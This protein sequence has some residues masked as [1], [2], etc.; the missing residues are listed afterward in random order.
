MK[1]APIPSVYFI[2]ALCALG[3]TI[4]HFSIQLVNVDAT[5]FIYH[6]NSGWGSALVTTFFI[7]SGF[8]LHYHYGGDKLELRR[9]YVKRW[10]GLY[11][12]FYIA[13][14][15]FWMGKIC[16][17][18]GPFFNGQPLAYF[19]TV[20]GLDGYIDVRTTTYYIIG[21]WFV[22]AIAI[23]YL[24]YPLLYRGYRKTA[25]GSFAAVAAVYVIFYDKCITNVYGFWTVSSCL[26]SFAFGML[27]CEYRKHLTKLPVLLVS[28]VGFVITVTVPLPLG[29]NLC[30]HMAGA[31]LYLLLN[32]AGE[33]LMRRKWIHSL[34]RELGNLSYPIFLIHHQ[35][36][37]RVTGSWQP[38]TPWK[39]AVIFLF[40][41]M[42]IL[43]GA[44]AL[45]VLT[46]AVM[47]WADQQL[48]RGKSQPPVS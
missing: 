17:N 44:K 34:F 10:R 29:A 14:F 28:L 32:A 22:G 45:S 19:W 9:Y 6:A 42:Q 41:L 38:G 47:R 4:F 23:M 43:L 27:C 13:Y 46:N 12:M 3:I 24:L 7:V 11:P 31:F 37:M 48:A 20:L 15:Y 33:V 8:L 21:E 5:P 35:V 25:L 1:K 18:R 2:K 39:V 30:D 16:D 36:I 26:V 40:A